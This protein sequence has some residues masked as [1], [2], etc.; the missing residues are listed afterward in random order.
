MWMHAIHH[1]RPA[2]P[3]VCTRPEKFFALITIRGR[4]GGLRAVYLIYISFSSL[5][6][7]YVR[8]IRPKCASFQ[9][10]PL[11]VEREQIAV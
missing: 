6:I 9:I 11:R 8:N 1:R 10:R 5:R 2:F 4:V 3:A 7:R